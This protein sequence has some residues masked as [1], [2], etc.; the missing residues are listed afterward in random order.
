MN[1]EEVK[2]YIKTNLKLSVNTETKSEYIGD[3]HGGESMYKDYVTVTVSLELEGEL[4]S[5]DTFYIG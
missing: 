1:A 4:I 3:L 2:Q 5:T